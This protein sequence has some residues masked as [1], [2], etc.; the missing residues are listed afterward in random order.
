[1]SNSWLAGPVPSP[2]DPKLHPGHRPVSCSTGTRAELSGLHVAQIGPA[3][4][5][6]GYDVSGGVN[7]TSGPV[8]RSSQFRGLLLAVLAALVVVL[9]ASTEDRCRYRGGRSDEDPSRPRQPNQL[10]QARPTEQ[11]TTRRTRISGE[12][13]YVGHPLQPVPQPVTPRTH[14]LGLLGIRALQR[15]GLRHGRVLRIHIR[16]S[17]HSLDRLAMRIVRLDRHRRDGLLQGIGGQTDQPLKLALEIPRLTKRDDLAKP[18]P[19][20]DICPL[21]GPGSGALIP[22]G[23]SQVSAVAVRSPARCRR[24][25]RVLRWHRRSGRRLWRLSVPLWR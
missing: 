1:M 6:T 12:L 10:G 7:A 4:P 17:S 16:S 18:D 2:A 19:L 5:T 23:W 8:G 11:T 22:R 21:I 20:R 14:P 9:A 13:V 3:A 25:V 15:P 24:D